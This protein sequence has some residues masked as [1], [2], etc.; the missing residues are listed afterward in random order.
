MPRAKKQKPSPLATVPP[1]GASARTPQT[2]PWVAPEPEAEL[3]RQPAE[4]QVE[5]EP[6][7]EREPPKTDEE[8][9]LAFD[10]AEADLERAERDVERILTVFCD[11]E[12]DSQWCQPSFVTRVKERLAAAESKLIQAQTTYLDA[13]VAP[14]NTTELTLKALKLY[15]VALKH[16]RDLKVGYKVANGLAQEHVDFLRSCS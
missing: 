3:P 16:E 9:S 8:T 15:W 13:F 6:E 2:H 11:S 10:K 4:P 7:M 5:A 14:N 12:F 1:E